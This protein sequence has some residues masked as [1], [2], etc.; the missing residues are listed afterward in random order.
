MSVGFWMSTTTSVQGKPNLARSRI[1]QILLPL[2][3]E[4][5][6]GFTPDLRNFGRIVCAQDGAHGSLALQEIFDFGDLEFVAE[7]FVQR[8]DDGHA[9]LDRAAG[10]SVGD[11][12]V[13]PVANLFAEFAPFDR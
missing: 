12:D 3:L 11:E 8:P 6:Q 2:M 13:N 10:V 7:E 1:N 4:L 9:S 5:L